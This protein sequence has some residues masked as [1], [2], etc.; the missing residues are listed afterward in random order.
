VAP[1]A[2]WAL[3]GKSRSFQVNLK[4]AISGV[5][6]WAIEGNKLKDLQA[7]PTEGVLTLK[8]TQERPPEILT[9]EEIRTLLKKAK[10]H[11]HPW[12]PIWTVALLTGM[13]AGE[14]STRCHASA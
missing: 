5:Y 14:L 13:R 11:Q 4:A 3:D 12:Y 1:Q 7:I 6:R 8:K 9:L 10:S 2:P